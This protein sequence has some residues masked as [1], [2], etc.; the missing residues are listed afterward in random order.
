ALESQLGAYIDSYFPRAF[1]Q[2]ATLSTWLG[3]LDRTLDQ[4]LHNGTDNFGN[5]L[6]ELELSSPGAFVGAWALAPAAQKADA[7][8]AMSKAIQRQLRALIPLCHFQDLSNYEDV[9]P[10]AALLLYAAMVP[11]TGLV[12]DHGVIVNFD[13]RS[14]VYWDID[15]PG[16]VQAMANHSLT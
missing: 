3:D 16:N 6:L 1:G 14:D 5:T 7:Y 4:V 10:S 9:V 8:F 11:A 13:D 12:I 15:T 2:G